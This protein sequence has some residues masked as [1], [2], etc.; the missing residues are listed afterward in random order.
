MFPACDVEGRGGIVYHHSV[1]VVLLFVAIVTVTVAWRRS[2]LFLF[3][4]RHD[5]VLIW[6]FITHTSKYI[7]SKADAFSYMNSFFITADFCFVGL[8]FTLLTGSIVCA[9][10]IWRLQDGISPACNVTLT[11]QLPVSVFCNTLGKSYCLFSP[12]QT[13]PRHAA[14]DFASTILQNMLSVTMIN[15]LYIHAS[16]DNDKPPLYSQHLNQRAMSGIVWM[17]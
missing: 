2:L 9:F 13:G 10:L 5:H 11:N 17:S 6:G 15:H 16:C 7:C 4:G 3:A 12:V 14:E 8:C 1:A